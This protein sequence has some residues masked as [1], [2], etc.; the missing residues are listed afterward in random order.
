MAKKCIVSPLEVA[1][2]YQIVYL[3]NYTKMYNYIGLTMD[4][5]IKNATKFAIK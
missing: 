4:V 5:P 3:Y 1:I 2:R